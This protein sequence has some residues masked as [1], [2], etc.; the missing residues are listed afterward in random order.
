[1]NKWY[2]RA[3]WLAIVGAP[4]TGLLLAGRSC[5]NYEVSNDRI[6]AVSR[7]EGATGRIEYVKVSDGSEELIVEES[8]FMGSES[9]FGQNL[10]RDNNI[11]RIRVSKVWGAGG[12]RLQDILVRE[13]DFDTHRELFQRMDRALAEER[14]NYPPKAF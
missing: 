7:A 12:L 6:E 11:D 14:S 9:Y 2:G 5:N 13:E 3:L 4:L 8:G 1:M 10:D